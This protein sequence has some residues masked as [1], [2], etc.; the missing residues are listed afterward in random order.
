MKTEKKLTIVFGLLL[1]SCILGSLV[2]TALNTALSPIMEEFGI[3]AATA[4][5]LG[6]AY[7]LAMGIMV[8]TTAFL[9]RR[10]PSR[11]LFLA[12]MG[13]F[14]AGLLMDGAAWNFPVLVAGRILQ[15]IGCGILMSLSQV[16]ILTKYPEERRGTLMG[17]Y[18]L[19]VCA[20]PV[21][22]PTLAGIIVDLA[23]WKMIF[24]GSLG[25]ACVLFVLS[26]FFME[27][28]TEKEAVSFDVVSVA[29]CAAGYI[30]LTL[31]V[32]NISEIARAPFACLVPGVIGLAGTG[33]FVRR[34]LNQEQPFL[35]IRIFSNREFRLAVLASMLLY[36]VMMAGSM[37]IPVYIQSMRGY[38]A[39]VSGLI[40]MPGSL[41]TA[42]VSPIAGKLYDKFGVRKLYLAGTICLLAS[43]AGCGFLGAETPLLLIAGLFVLR[44]VAVGML[45]MP[46]VTWGM[47]TLEKR[48]AADGTSLLTSLRTIAGA[49][50]GALFMSVMTMCAGGT[51]TADM[52]HG[53]DMAFWGMTLLAAVLT[54]MAVFGI[55]AS[56]RD[57]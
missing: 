12:A 10:C 3:S 18:G 43:S 24:W 22:A 23:G 40:T 42:L 31:A 33:L 48:H 56:K 30:G 1:S 14:M 25:I 35:H 57:S 9:I 27:N 51:Q 55:G 5:W 6:S 29:L 16:I 7:S 47:S 44:S 34:Q 50:G 49:F 26:L 2:Q 21:L 53:T 11:K 54:G 36:A 39:T 32:G 28:L 8:L 15:A 38:S 20:A 46:T 37:L 17:V 41:A 52:I 4:Q 13:V 45:M 19:A